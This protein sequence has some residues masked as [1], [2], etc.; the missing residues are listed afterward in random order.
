MNNYTFLAIYTDIKDVTRVNNEDGSIS[1][2][3][4]FY[5]R[6]DAHRYEYLFDGEGNFISMKEIPMTEL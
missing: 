4:T 6:Y 2:F 1:V 5:D 3:G